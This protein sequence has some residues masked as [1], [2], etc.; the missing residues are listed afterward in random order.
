M[1]NKLVSLSVVGLLMISAVVFYSFRLSARG[2]K[3]IK[4][5]D[6]KNKFEIMLPEKPQEDKNKNAQDKDIITIRAALSQPLTNFYVTVT[7][8][9][10]NY[11]DSTFKRVTK[12]Y[13]TGLAKTYNE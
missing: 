2:D 5:T 1:K 11:T 12:D 10:A 3:W 7:H 13:M 8:L 6:K 9:P 4:Y